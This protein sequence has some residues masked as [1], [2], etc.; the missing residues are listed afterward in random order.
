MEERPDP[1]SKHTTQ[2]HLAGAAPNP[3]T[4]LVS[5]VSPDGLSSGRV[6]DALADR[7]PLQEFAGFQNGDSRMYPDVVV[8]RCCRIVANEDESFLFG[9]FFSKKYDTIVH[10]R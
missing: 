3:L 1:A 10:D 8:R 6:I 2:F 5:I 7:W 4:P 9:F